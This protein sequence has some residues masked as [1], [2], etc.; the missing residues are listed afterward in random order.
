MRN[1]RT[2]ST[3]RARESNVGG[4]CEARR[5]PGPRACSLRT[6]VDPPPASLKNAGN[7]HAEA[8]EKQRAGLGYPVDRFNAI[9]RFDAQ[10]GAVEPNGFTPGGNGS[11]AE[12][13]RAVLDFIS[14]CSQVQ[15]NR[16][17]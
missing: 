17:A 16:V 10:V 15:V 1:A 6:L 3:R 8:G 9:D 11:D 12:Q 5:C 2:R 14:E 13:Q 7:R 4:R